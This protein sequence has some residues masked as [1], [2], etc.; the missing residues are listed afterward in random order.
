M[1]QESWY[2]LLEGR[3]D[4]KTGVFGSFFAYGQHC[5]EALHFAGLAASGQGF[6][7][8][9]LVEAERLDI[10]SNYTPPDD[11][12]K[13]SEHVSMRPN[14]HSYPIIEGQLEFVPPVGIV[15]STNGGEYDYALIK[16]GFVAYGRDEQDIFRFELVAGIESLVRTF[17]EAIL[18]L[19]K[20]DLFSIYVWQH[21]EDGKDEIWASGAITT[22]NELLSFL[23]KYREC[24]LENGYLNCV[25]DIVE[26]STRLTLDQHKKIQFYTKNEGLFNVFGKRMIDLGFKQLDVFY[27]LEFGY[28][29]WHYRPYNSLSREDF[30]D[31]LKV[32]KFG[33]VKITS[34]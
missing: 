31:M 20:F 2:F 29:H 25:I 32:E 22:A 17:L 14:I 23:T 1:V 11:L 24:T 30:M 16:D 28:Y 9:H 18:I 10:I 13:I 8:V 12:L 27:D 4:E 7:N 3:S 19:P 33:P 26:D 34:E 5:G 6:I 21:W 15:K